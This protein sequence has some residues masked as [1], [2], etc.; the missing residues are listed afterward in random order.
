MA[1]LLEAHPDYRLQRRLRPRLQWP[2]ATGA[3][4]RVVVLDTETTGLDATKDAIIELALLRVDIDNATGLP[5]GEVR[6]FDELEDPGRTIPKEVVALTGLTDA[7]VRGKRLDEARILEILQDADLVI[8]HNAGFDRPFAERR[9]ARFAELPW[10]CSFADIDWKAQGHS[11]SK[12]ESLA[13]GLGWFYD[14][15]R[16]EMDCHA[17]LAVLAAPLPKLPHTGLA[18][19]LEAA[20][21]PSFRLQATMAPFDAK[22]KLKARG[23][24][25]NGDLRVWATRLNDADSLAAECAWLKEN[26]Y[27]GRAVKVQ[28]E[29]LDALSKYSE[30]GGKVQMLA[31]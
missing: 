26:V 27:S 15:H 3:V 23:Y 28:L 31:L 29:E 1:Q 30:R 8:A 6:V 4:T 2:Q 7:D 22:D 17:L 16:A 5:V 21:T 14:A 24:R 10:A 20:A 11:S 25:W 19:L 12:L 9:L 18:H 13:Q